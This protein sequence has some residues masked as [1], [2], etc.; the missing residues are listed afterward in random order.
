[1]KVN[2]ILSPNN[3]DDLYFNG[4]TTVVIDVLRATSVILKALDSRA[5]EVIPVSSI[6][7]AM[8]I[9][10]NSHGGQ[11]LLCGERNT[12]IIEGFDLGNSPAEFS[13]ENV[14]CKSVVLFTTNGTKAIVKAK[15][16]EKVFIASFNN[17]ST[18]AEYLVQLENDIEIIASGANGIFCLEDTVCAGALVK[19]MLEKKSDIQLSDATNASL[20]LNE[21]YGSDIKEML[22]NCEHGQILKANGFEN[23]IE[24][25]SIV[26]NIPLIPYFADGAIK[27]LKDEILDSN[28]NN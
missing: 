23:D 13:E 28:A 18:L 20:V 24:F 2:V 7:F 14:A 27:L 10:V 11:T 1:M 16:S 12:Q 8:K 22:T 5:K 26:D 9:S 3:V 6:D 15:Y 19:L 4:K 21:K 17:L 25:C